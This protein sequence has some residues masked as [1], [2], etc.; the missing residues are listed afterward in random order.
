MMK[1]LTLT[2]TQTKIVTTLVQAK[3][4]PHCIVLRGILLR[5]Y[6]Q[7]G[8][9]SRV[10]SKHGVGR[11]TVR[12]WYQ[13]WQ[14]AQRELDRLEAEHQAGT[15]SLTKYAREIETLLSDAPRPG[16]PATF[17]EAQKQQII[18][19][20]TRRPE[21]EGVPVTHWS[22]ETL[23]QTVIEKGIVPSISAAQIGRF[24]K[25]GH[26]AAPSQPILG[27]SQHRRLG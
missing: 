24:L 20:A 18:T 27:A 19:M 15:V 3:T 7:S 4:S 5:D 21:D 22:H 8:N 23:A 14:M 17:T 2:P 26:V 10:A 11:D 1:K 9:M 6:A 13:R 25:E 16:A 12:H